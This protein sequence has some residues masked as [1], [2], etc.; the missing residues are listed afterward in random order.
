MIVFATR[1]GRVGAVTSSG[2]KIDDIVPF[3]A[4]PSV[5][6]LG[7]FIR[8]TNPNNNKSCFAIVLDVGPWNE[9]DDEYVFKG[10][11]PLSEKGI[12]KSMKGTNK[13]GIDLSESVWHKLEMKDNGNVDWK[14]IEDSG[15][16]ES[17]LETD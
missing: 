9:H 2:Y 10:A 16:D 12:S 3:V 11:R 4:L 6:A 7:M 1:E 17:G 15:S 5:A 13:A 8:V 14:F